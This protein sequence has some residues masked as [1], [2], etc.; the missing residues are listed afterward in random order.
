MTNHVPNC[1]NRLNFHINQS[2]ESVS[3]LQ[4]N[5]KWIIDVHWSTFKLYWYITKA[6]V[7]ESTQFMVMNFNAICLSTNVSQ[8]TALFPS[9][10]W[11]SPRSRAFCCR[12]ALRS[13]GIM[14]CVEILYKLSALLLLFRMNHLL[15]KSQPLS[16]PAFILL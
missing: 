5:L 3:A 4:V 14:Y 13:T 10:V 15:E 8:L 9:R 12:I 6:I 1:A 2:T 16:A 11:N 7:C